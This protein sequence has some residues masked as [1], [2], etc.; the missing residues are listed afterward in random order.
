M[1]RR[2]PVSY[3]LEVNPRFS[4]QP[5]EDAAAQGAGAGGG[6]TSGDAAA[7]G[8]RGLGGR[9]AFGFLGG[10]LFPARGPG[11]AA[12]ELG[13]EALP[14]AAKAVINGPRRRRDDRGAV[15]A[16][17]GEEDHGEPAPVRIGQEA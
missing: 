5:F 2:Q 6:L 3:E 17:A 1:C 10:E 12:A 4:A 13:R 7:G 15:V 8:W 16:A 14:F 11:D 9:L